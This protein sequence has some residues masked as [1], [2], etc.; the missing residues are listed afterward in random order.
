MKKLLFILFGA[1]SIV[2][3]IVTLYFQAN[4]PK[5]AYVEIGEV[6]NAFELKKELEEDIKRVHQTRTYILDSLEIQLNAM[7]AKI[8]NSGKSI[9][10]QELKLF[11]EARNDYFRKQKTFTEDG[12]SVSEQYNDR[13]WKQLNQY[14]KDYGDEKGYTYIFGADGSGALMFAADPVNVTKEV[15]EYVNLKY[16][17][18]AK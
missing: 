17:G 7:A 15:T 5:T 4:I 10:D 1:C 11:E 6:Y 12:E 16:K 13:I 9:S 8:E 2:S 14:I 18:G 3:L